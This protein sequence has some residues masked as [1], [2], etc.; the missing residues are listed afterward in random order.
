MTFPEDKAGSPPNSF[1]KIKN[2]NVVILTISRSIILFLFYTFGNPP[3]IRF[4]IPH[5]FLPRLIL[6]IPPMPQESP[7]VLAHNQ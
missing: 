5:S 3:V 4:S 7:H 1:T 2:K 6:N